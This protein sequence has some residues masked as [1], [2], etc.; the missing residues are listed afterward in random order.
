VKHEGRVSLVGGGPGAPGLLTLRAAELLAEADVVA[1]D[2]LAAP[3]LLD[4]ARE[5]ALLVPV[6]RRADGPHAD[7]YRLHPTVLEHARAGRHVVRLKAG[8]PFIFGRGGEEAEELR[9]AGIQYEVVP[10][11]SSAL[12]AA[13]S[14]GIPLT[15]RDFASDVTFASGHDL[16]ARRRSATNFAS[17]GQTHG[18]VVLFMASKALEAN[19]ARLVENGRP[20]STPAAY[21]AAAS[22]DRQVVVEGTLATLA[23]RAR[24]VDRKAPGLVIVGDVVR[25][26]ERI[27]PPG[28]LSGRRLVVGRGRPGPSRLAATLRSLGAQVVEAPKLTVTEPSSWSP[29]HDALATFGEHRACIF[30]SPASVRGFFGRLATLKRDVRTLPAVPCIALGEGTAAALASV[31]LVAVE[32][33]NETCEAAL[34]ALASLRGEGPVLV[35]AGEGERPVLLRYLAARN[36]ATVVVPTHALGRSLGRAALEP[37]DAVVFPCSSSVAPILDGAPALRTLPAIVMG[38]ETERAA[39]ALGAERII[40]AATDGRDALVDAVLTTFEREISDV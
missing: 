21:I 37:A 19:L 31:G 28:A 30:T 26:R 1:Y 3:E 33:C 27:A 17:L 14:A 35:V 10:G 11:V 20:A 39:R 22:T 38:P 23:E 8:D 6:G 32:A 34:D 40:V 13:A 18:T 25:L 15:H 4:L 24:G 2:E 16:Q 5:D 9:E 7:A 36:V 29:L 12:G